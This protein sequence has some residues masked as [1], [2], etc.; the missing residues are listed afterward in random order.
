MLY[1]KAELYVYT[2]GK[3]I[4]RQIFKNKYQTLKNGYTWRTGQW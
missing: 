4:E 1:I 2:I 3:C